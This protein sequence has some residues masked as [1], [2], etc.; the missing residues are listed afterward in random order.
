MTQ[1][2][3]SRK[4]NLTMAVADVD[5]RVVRNPNGRYGGSSSRMDSS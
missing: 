5:A 4:E 3:G 1:R 2:F